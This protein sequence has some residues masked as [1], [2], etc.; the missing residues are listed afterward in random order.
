VLS[1]IFYAACLPSFVSGFPGLDFRSSPLRDSNVNDQ[2]DGTF[3]G[4]MVSPG[5]YRVLILHQCKGAIVKKATTV[6]VM[7]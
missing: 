2:W 3:N 1:G 4:Q 5:V 6:M 7:N